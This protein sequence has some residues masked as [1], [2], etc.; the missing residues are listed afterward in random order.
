MKK[1]LVFPLALA[2]SGMALA[3]DGASV[4][5]QGWNSSDWEVEESDI[6]VDP[7]F[8]F[9]RLDNGM[10][11][12]LRQ[13]S[14]PEGTALVRLHIGSG[15]LD[16][17]DSERGLAHFIEHMAFNGSA[18]VP[19][20]EMV[21]L[22]EREGLAFG[23]D[24]NATTT[25]ETTTYKLDLPRNDAAL[26]DT[27]LMLM[28]ETAS[29]LTIA[30]D[31]VD[32]ERGVVL[33]ERRD[34]YSFAYKETVDQLDFT[35]PGARFND[36]LPIGTAE[37]LENATAEEL[38]ALYRRTY[39][40]A[41]A[42]L[43]IVGDFPLA[44]MET[45]VRQHFAS[46][47][48]APDPAE[49]YAGPAD[50]TR[51][52]ETRIYLDP[53]LNER[54]QVMRLAPWSERPDTVA[55]RQQALLRQIGYGV[56]NRRLQTLA[57]AADAPFRSAGYGTGDVFEA[58][59]TTSLVVDTED[60]KWRSGL[61]VAATELRR[62]LA[63]GFSEA[64]VAEQVARIRT[65]LEN[66]VNGSKTRT[67]GA[68]MAAA[69]QLVEDQ[70]V[71]S[72]PES[73]L[74]RFEAFA[75]QITPETTLA[76]VLAEAAPMDDPLIRFEGRAAPEGGEAA[77]RE[78]WQQAQMAELSAPDHAA[79]AEFAYTDF[80]QPGAVVADTRDER[81]GFRLIRFANGVRLNL[82]Q[83]DI[84][85][86]RISF[87]LTLDGG[88]L[89]ETRDAPLKTALVS[90]L[91]QGGLGKH[92][93]DQLESI[94]AGRSVQLSIA[95]KDDG[96]SMGGG[97]TPRDLE[98]QLQLVAALLTDPGYRAEGVERY[99]R[100]VK[101]FFAS[102]D[103]TPAQALGNQLGGILSDQDPRFTLQPQAAYEA[104]SFEQLAA[105]IGD[106]LAH[107]A[108]EL[109]LVGDF[110]EQTAIALVAKT[111][112]A[113]PPREPDFNARMEAR[114]RDFTQDRSTRQITHSGEPD[115][116]LVRM[117]WPTTDDSDLAE[118]L[119][120][121]LLDRVVQIELQD[122][123]RE[124]LGKSYSPSSNSSPSKAWPGYGTFALAASVD[125]K[126]VEATRAAIRDMLVSLRN[127]P[128]DQDVLDRA[129][130]PLLE[131]YD[132][133]LDT[134]GGWMTLADRAQSEAT[135]LER[136]EL[137]PDILK[138]ITPQDILATAQRYL[139]PE[140]AVEV[141]VLPKE[142]ATTE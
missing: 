22:L 126:E 82:K 77:L 99:R 54:V 115:Q 138:A 7:A 98:L 84:R 4:A 38:R 131:A 51:S 83:T 16:E 63:F 3:Q 23:A 60:G 48:A 73:S 132:N 121:S 53:A 130:Q 127:A 76:A 27:A 43:V 128:V 97:T 41:N 94:L 65:A 100:S 13:N 46:W 21:K 29:N 50:I 123:L 59:R 119:R 114:Q 89:L 57:R 95:S 133:M 134:L 87:R 58:A 137:A 52:G 14:T 125:V 140:D 56:I 106:R 69:L 92:S 44:E 79:A 102:L 136:F 45:A 75:P 28:R 71:P 40:P 10:R 62:A 118:T 72:T 30:Q 18:N 61:D 19:E 55:N 33:S 142:S 39:V 15:S 116:A 35:A 96:F 66:G 5:P 104:L 34:R 67:N 93:Q 107:G 81:F 37:V 42:V 6:P 135:R 113:L 86:D 111:L 17:T 80:G 124:D 88:Q 91:P 122:Q 141:L 139:A 26:L 108:I 11:Y 24:T 1:L 32:R 101:S 78:A 117:T 47:Q 64:E 112:G 70:Q 9:G 105:D 103:A 31:A 90:S 49:P 109:A 129:R 110:D 8:R 85:K 120:L 12:I 2:L 36:R 20:G 25:F 74:A 68:L